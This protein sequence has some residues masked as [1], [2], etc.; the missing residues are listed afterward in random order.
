MKRTDITKLFP[1]ATDE[2]INALMDINGADI[3]AA[4]RGMD[5]LRTQLSAAKSDLEASQKAAAAAASAEELKTAQDRAAALESELNGL[6]LSNQLRD[7][8]AAVAKEKNIPVELLTGDSEDACKAQADGIL[9]FARPNGYPVL[10][11]SGE[12][13]KSGAGLTTRDQFAA[14]AEQNQI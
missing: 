10:R 13:N 2:Q 3:N 1:D 4:K 8:R 12:V 7:M 9:A 11:D 6:K 14:W 5:D